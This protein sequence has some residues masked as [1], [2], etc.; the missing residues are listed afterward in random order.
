[1]QREKEMQRDAGGLGKVVMGI[2]GIRLGAG[3]RILEKT[4]ELW[5]ISETRQNPSAMETPWTL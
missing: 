4:L 5:V 3:G 1:M 2:Q